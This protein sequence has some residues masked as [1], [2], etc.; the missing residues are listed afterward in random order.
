MNVCH[1]EH[2]MIYQSRSHCVSRTKCSTL[3]LDT[4]VVA[5]SCV[6]QRFVH[7]KYLSSHHCLTLFRRYIMT[8]RCGISQNLVNQ[9]PRP[10][11]LL[12]DFN[13]QSSTVVLYTVKV[14]VSRK[15]CRILQTSDWKTYGYRPSVKEICKKHVVFTPSLLMMVGY[16]HMGI[17]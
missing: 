2:R 12:D 3:T 6:S 9:L 1:K 10:Y 17:R 15:C 4:T 14:V 16:G 5:L 13:T 11:I 7:R 8:L